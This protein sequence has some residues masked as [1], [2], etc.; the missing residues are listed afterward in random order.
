M[1]TIY[2]ERSTKSHGHT[3]RYT[4]NENNNYKTTINQENRTRIELY[5]IMTNSGE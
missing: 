3:N 4:V 5:M 1:F 2:Y